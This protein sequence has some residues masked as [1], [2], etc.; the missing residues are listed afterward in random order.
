MNRTIQFLAIAVSAFLLL[1]SC[2]TTQTTNTWVSPSYRGSPVSDVFVIA[3][4]KQKDLRRSFENK[5]V[6][7]LKATGVR[8]VPS[9]SEMP[10]DQ[11]IEKEAV[12]AIVEK[13][14]VDSVLVTHLVSMTEK[15]VSTPSATSTQAGPDD[16]H[17][18][19]YYESVQQAYHTSAGAQYNPTRVK[20][21]LESK[22][23]D[24]KTEKPIWS[25]QSKTIDPQSTMEM[26]DAAIAAFIR[27][28]Q[29]NKLLP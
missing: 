17:G 25:A 8:A 16:Y 14:G 13:L 7:Q 20:V 23:Y 21:R 4:T 1:L 9:A 5:F 11:K 10:L 19:G 12:L 28:L 15:E 29:Q 26:F 6:Q 2:S 3:V 22:L 27:N 24:V 18:G